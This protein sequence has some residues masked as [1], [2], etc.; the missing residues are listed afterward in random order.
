[1]IMITARGRLFVFIILFFLV[2]GCLMVVGVV[3]I[4]E[5]EAP[6]VLGLTYLLLAVSLGA[7][8]EA[9][10]SQDK[11]LAELERKLSDRQSPAEPDQPSPVQKQSG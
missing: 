11:R 5:N 1:M 7:I 4:R 8:V 6:M 9:I 2:V 3:S 10:W